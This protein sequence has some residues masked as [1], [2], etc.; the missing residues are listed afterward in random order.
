M[1]LDGKNHTHYLENP[2][3]FKKT[4]QIHLNAIKITDY[5]KW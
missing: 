3:E 5:K 4:Y 1:A 2:E